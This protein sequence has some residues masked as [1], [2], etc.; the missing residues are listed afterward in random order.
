MGLEVR[1]EDHPLSGLKREVGGDWGISLHTL[2]SDGQ[3]EG[4]GRPLL[5]IEL[6]PQG[7]VLRANITF[8]RVLTELFLDGSVHL[9]E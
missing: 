6:I 4:L 5:E 1:V 2:L 3:V 9:V 8:K 7:F